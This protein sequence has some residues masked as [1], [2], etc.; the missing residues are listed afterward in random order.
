MRYNT[1]SLGYVVEKVTDQITDFTIALCRGQET[2]SRSRHPAGDTRG[3]PVPS[4]L[5]ICRISRNQCYGNIRKQS[6]FFLLEQSDFL[7]YHVRYDV[8]MTMK[9]TMRKIFKKN[10]QYE[11]EMNKYYVGQKAKI[12]KFA[13]L[14]Q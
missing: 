14:V 7:A 4:G 3:I 2:E 12:N 10:K 8:Q 6:D 1:I 11:R 9:A 13:L 5:R